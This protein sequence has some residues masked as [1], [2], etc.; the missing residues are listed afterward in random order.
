MTII[1]FLPSADNLQTTEIAVKEIIGRL[2]Y[3]AKD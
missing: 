3:L 1:D 2:F